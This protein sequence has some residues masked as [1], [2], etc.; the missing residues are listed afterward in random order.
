MIAL[1]VLARQR[2]A[3]PHAKRDE[4]VHQESGRT[5]RWKRHSFAFAQPPEETG[6]PGCPNRNRCPR[7]RNRDERGPSVSHRGGVFC[8]GG[9]GGAAPYAPFRICLTVGG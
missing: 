1:P 4:C 9:G 8:L 2:L 3:I 7:E 5:W 6:R